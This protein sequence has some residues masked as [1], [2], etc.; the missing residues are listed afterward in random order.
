MA[1]STRKPTK[2]SRKTDDKNQPK[3]IF[4]IAGCLT[5]TVIIVAIF[6][7][8]YILLGINSDGLTP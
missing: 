1:S 5:F 3:G 2:S 8:V 7:I 4:S 6:F